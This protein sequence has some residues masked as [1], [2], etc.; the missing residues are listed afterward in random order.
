[1]D[2]PATILIRNGRVIDPASGTD[3][4]LDI[5]LADGRIAAVKTS[6]DEA[7]D[8]VIDA[9]RL[10]VVPGLIDMHVHLREPGAENKETIV[11]GSRAA[12]RGGFTT[13]CAMPNTRPVNDNRKVTSRILEEAARSAVVNVLPIAAVTAGSKG[14]ELTDMAALAE[15]GAAAFSDDGSPVAS[16][17]LMLI[18]LE[19]AMSLGRPLIDHCED[20][21]LSR[22]GVM[23]AGKVSARLGLKG[24]PAAAED[25]M[26]ARDIILARDLGAPV[27]IAH[28]STKGAALAVKAAKDRG[29][30]VSA[31]ATPHHLLLSDE[32]VVPDDADFKMNPPLRGREDVEALVAAL[33]AGVIDVI[34]TDHA[35]HTESEKARG[36]EKAPFGIVG[37]ETAVP[38]VLDRLV[39]KGVI[40][41]RRFAELMSLNPARLLGL[42]AKG[43]I[44]EGADADLTLLNLAKD[45]VVDKAAFES[46]SRN[47]PFHGW[48]LKGQA[49]MT[50]VGGRVVYPFG[51]GGRP[52]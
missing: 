36:F 14:E 46:K 45:V 43:R 1:M 29:I 9:S 16:S 2:R 52:E 17:R 4:T 3:E 15:A 13:V 41:L 12:A 26:V 33:R 8:R 32:A 5:L 48:K 22:D 6:V 39:H 50:I 10:V 23:H 24:I 19:K 11:S 35:P 21:G 42:P 38:L 25:V 51:P 44:A 34:A 30:R 47:T 40:T 49:V 31:E 7:A 28:L 20:K 27:H 18:A 37:L